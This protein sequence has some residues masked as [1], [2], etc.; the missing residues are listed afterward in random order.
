MSGGGAVRS[1][2]SEPETK[3]AILAEAIPY[4]RRFAN[5]VVV[6]KYGGNARSKATVTRK[7]AWRSFA[8][9]V[10]DPHAVRR[11]V[12]GGGSR[13][14]SPNRSALMARLGKTAGVPRR[15]ARHRRRDPRHRPHGARRKG[16]PGDCRRAERARPGGPR[17]LRRGRRTD[18]GFASRPGARLRRRRRGGRFGHTS[19]TARRRA[20]TGCRDDRRRRRRPGLQHQRRHRRR[21]D[22]EV[23]VVR[24][25]HLP[26]RRRRHPS[27][28]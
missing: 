4:V 3:A 12:A 7:Q 26:H 6:V 15:P 5:K 27:R 11:D 14:R 13:R 16:E 18:H 1:W 23:A 25:A 28:P 17:A 19:A 20:G 2:G 8:E 21:G 10:A 22:R 9:D 24:E